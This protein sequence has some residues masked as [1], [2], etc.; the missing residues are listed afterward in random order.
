[1]AMENA[2]I[3][4]DVVEVQEFPSLARR[5]RVMGVPKT[6]INEAVQFLG[7]VSEESFMGKVLEAIGKGEG[8]QEA[9]GPAPS[10]MV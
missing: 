9:E 3:R 8:V 5:Y 7:A 6:V 4:A 10:T 2:R 1:M